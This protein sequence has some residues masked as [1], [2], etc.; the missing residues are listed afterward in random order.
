MIAIANGVVRLV[1]DLDH[2]L[3]LRQLAAL[4][5]LSQA[6]APVTV[7]AVASE[8]NIHKPATSRA[9]VALERRGWIIRAKGE[10]DR[11]DVLVSVTPNGRKA[12]AA[13]S[14]SMAGEPPARPAVRQRKTA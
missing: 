2:D 10:I 14:G 13:I 5:L 12:M 7:R 4:V 3:T 8:L 9:L 1:Q 6:E 11:R